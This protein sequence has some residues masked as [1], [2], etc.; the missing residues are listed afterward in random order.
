MP[1]PN[2]PMTC[3]DARLY[4]GRISGSS[5]TL[6]LY[7][8]AGND[9]PINRYL[10]FI[11]LE[12]ERVEDSMRRIVLMYA[13]QGRMWC[14]QSQ[15]CPNLFITYAKRDSPMEF[16]YLGTENAPGT[17][18]PALKYK[19]SFYREYR[20]FMVCQAEPL[21][22]FVDVEHLETDW[23]Q[24]EEFHELFGAQEMPGLGG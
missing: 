22:P 10:N 18:R 3:D 17:D 12:Y 14:G 15:E 16:E 5:P 8:D 2:D 19:Y 11:R 21:P 24:I 9:F 20:L 4:T 1:R 23:N 7:L 13:H 6:Y